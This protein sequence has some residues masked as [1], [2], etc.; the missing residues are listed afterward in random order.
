M[1]CVSSQRESHES[2]ASLSHPCKAPWSHQVILAPSKTYTR[3]HHKLHSSTFGLFTTNSRLGYSGFPFFGDRFFR[4]IFSNYTQSNINQLH[5]KYPACP[6]SSLNL[7]NLGEF[8]GLSYGYLAID[9]SNEYP[10]TTRKKPPPLIAH[11]E[12]LFSRW[13][14]WELNG[15]LAKLCLVCAMTFNSSSKGFTCNCNL[16]T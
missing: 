11:I 2:A 9:Q 6:V 16:R 15:A 14:V 3:P 13:L 8:R 1:I 4:I 12:M 7:G 5:R 10:S